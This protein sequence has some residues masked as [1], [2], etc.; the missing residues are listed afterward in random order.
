MNDHL[1]HSFIETTPLRK[2]RFYF[3][4]EIPDF[5]VLTDKTKRGLEVRDHFIDEKTGIE[6]VRG[7]IYDME[8]TGHKVA[9]KW[10]YPKSRYDLI[11]VIEDAE[12]M[13]QKYR[14]IREMTC[15][16]DI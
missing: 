3:I 10:L 1:S 14:E 11:S 9:I 12:K 16:D 8:G 5:Y 15:P 6:S 2:G 4:F 7:I 13:E